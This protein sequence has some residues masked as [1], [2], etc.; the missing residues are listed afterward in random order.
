MQQLCFCVYIKIEDAAL[1]SKTHF[2]EKHKSGVINIAGYDI[3]RRDRKKRRGGGAA[4]ILKNDWSWNTIDSIDGD[5]HE[6]ELLWV[7]A[8]KDGCKWIFGVIYHPPKPVYD[9]VEFLDYLEVSIDYVEKLVST[10]LLFY[11]LAPAPLQRG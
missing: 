8:V 9:T 1:I 4:I 7:R 3:I 2:K 5:R 11:Y 10:F 6:F